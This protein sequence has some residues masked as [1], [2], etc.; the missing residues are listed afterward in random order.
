MTIAPRRRRLLAALLASGA[1]GACLSSRAMAQR[2]AEAA[3]PL[4]AD[5]RA[6]ARQ[7]RRERKP[8]LLFFTTPG[9]PYCIEV[10]RSYLA[11]RL[12]QPDSGGVLIRE[13]SIL[14][15]RRL[16]DLDGR[17]ITERA[18]AA[19]FAVAA[20]PVVRLVDERLQ[21]LSDPLIGLNAAFYESYLQSAIDAARAALARG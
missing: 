16:I 11:P 6:L 4:P 12:A 1:A 18:L 14:G 15:E 3:L 8:L 5:L 20:V 17:P 9:C 19:R 21:P 7:V 13:L 2:A 10:R